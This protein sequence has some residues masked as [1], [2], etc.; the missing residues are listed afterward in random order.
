M[1][2]L[3]ALLATIPDGRYVQACQDGYH[4]EEIFAADEAVYVER[5]FADSACA[6][7]SL[8]VR[9]YGRVEYVGQ[10]EKPADA[11]G[12]DFE[13]TRVTLTPKTQWVADLY[14]ERT[15]CGIDSW[16]LD[17]EEEI[18]GRFCDF[19]GLGRFSAV[20]QAGDHRYGIY[21]LDKEGSVY[22]GRL[23]PWSDGTSPERRPR[24]WDPAPY[25]RM[26]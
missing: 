11:N 3:L 4:R 1:I 21:R 5:N 16:A 19:Y 2:A 8:E 22:F 7:L 9:S 15:V 12:I 17:R 20:P 23:E 6:S 18:T 24:A 10:L 14:R 25:R 13:F 26:N